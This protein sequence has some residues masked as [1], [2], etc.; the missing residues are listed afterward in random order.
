MKAR[1]LSLRPLAIFLD[2]ITI[3]LSFYVSFK[4]RS[5]LLRFYE[6]GNVTHLH[7][8]V[9]VLI[10]VLAGSIWL[11]TIFGA[12]K[13]PMFVSLWKELKIVLKVVVLGALILFAGIFFLQLDVSFLPR[14]FM[15]L[16]LLVNFSFL[17]FEK[18]IIY[19][20]MSRE[21]MKGV[22]LQSAVV[23]GDGEGVARFLHTLKVHP[24]YGLKAI[25]VFCNDDSTASTVKNL[26]VL[27]PVEGLGDF[28]QKSHV[29]EVIVI[30][31]KDVN[32]EKILE[33]C[34]EEGVKTRI[35]PD[36]LNRLDVNIALDRLGD[37][38]AINLYGHHEKEWQI[39]FKRAMDIILSS[40]MILVLSPLL[41]AISIAI[42]INSPGPVFY[43]WRVMGFNKKPFTSWKFRT[44]IVNADEIKKELIK[45]NEMSGPVFKIK[46]DPRITPIGRVLRRFSMDELPQ[47]FSVLKGDMSL[48]GP[49]PPLV[50]EVEKFERWH[51]KKLRIKPGITCLWQ[52]SG[53][54]AIK[55]FDEWVRLDVKYIEN[56]SLWLDIKIL[57]KTIP[58]VF[59]GT[60]H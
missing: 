54:N 16:F 20:L 14:T 57:F 22:A 1:H 24:E 59:L 33:V 42:K 46:N 23:V 39:F 31:E 15:L 11:L 13:K 3:L 28:L 9:Y 6:F 17:I 34:E 43:H 45:E 51:G 56:W 30:P 27:G 55:D 2:I 36:L 41:I 49:R 5:G 12:Y 21:R 38:I 35:V 50:T 19:S 58:A 25:G 10:I 18:T 60:G 4:V 37:M 40:L 26:A 48:V 8:Y 44:M 47:F 52:V 32:I 29:D 7:D 53:R